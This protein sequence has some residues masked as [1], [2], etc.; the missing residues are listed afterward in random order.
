MSRKVIAKKELNKLHELEK[1][2]KEDPDNEG[3]P[4]KRAASPSPL[5]RVTEAPS[6][7]TS[8]SRTGRGRSFTN[9]S[10]L[11]KLRNREA[12]SPSPLQRSA[13]SRSRSSVAA[14]GVQ[15]QQ[16]SSKERSTS[17]SQVNSTASSPRTNPAVADKS[18]TTRTRLSKS[19][20]PLARTPLP[21]KIKVSPNKTGSSTY[22]LN[23]NVHG[24]LTKLKFKVSNWQVLLKI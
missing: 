3:K 24:A 4:R 9:Q 2:L 21:P 19:P 17:P 8:D 12:K 22:K 7:T 16:N 13:L 14:T 11:G 5:G 1:S 18:L 20:S 10:D 6:A 15:T 23:Q